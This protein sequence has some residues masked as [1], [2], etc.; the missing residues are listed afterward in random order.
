M[1]AVST[2]ELGV[3]GKLARRLLAFLAR[4]SLAKEGETAHGHYIQQTSSRRPL[5]AGHRSDGMRLEEQV[6]H[7][8]VAEHAARATKRGAGGADRALAERDQ[9]HRRERSVVP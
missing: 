2:L 1:F 6:H 8:R 4:S 3:G 5:P 9:V 7:A